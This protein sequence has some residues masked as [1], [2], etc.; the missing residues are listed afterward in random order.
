[1]ACQNIYGI[2]HQRQFT[3]NVTGGICIECLI[4]VY[5]L[6]AHNNY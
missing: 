5:I 1:M 4:A 2:Y 3:S 6:L